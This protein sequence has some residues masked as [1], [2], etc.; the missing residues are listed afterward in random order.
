MVINC[1]VCTGNNYSRWNRDL[2]FVF[3][4]LVLERRRD[5]FIIGVVS[6]SNTATLLRQRD[7]TYR[8]RANLRNS[9]WTTSKLVHCDRYRNLEFL[10]L[11][12]FVITQL[13]SCL[14]CRGFSRVSCY[15]FL[16]LFPVSFTSAYYHATVSRLTCLLSAFKSVKRWLTALDRPDQSQASNVYSNYGN[17]CRSFGE[18]LRKATVFFKFRFITRCYC[19]FGILVEFG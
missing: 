15:A 5:T 14:L 18:R 11:F 19:N 12:L 2:A 17:L 7:L 6:A 10:V 16:F 8:D 3:R 1:F 4:L 9:T 13:I